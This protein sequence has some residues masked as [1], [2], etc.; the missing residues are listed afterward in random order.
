MRMPYWS[1]LLALLVFPAFA[2]TPDEEGGGLPG[3]DAGELV[4]D[5]ASSAPEGEAPNQAEAWPSGAALS[6]APVAAP[7]AAPM[8]GVTSPLAAALASLAQDPIFASATVSVQVVDVRTGEE[9]YQWGD[10]KALAPASVMKVV[11]TAAALKRLGPNYKFPTWVLHDAAEPPSTEGVLA[12]SLYVKGQGDP[13]MVVERLWRMVFD[14]RMRGIR[15]IKGDVVFDDAY[16]AGGPLV[17]G[18]TKAEDLANPPTYFASLGALSVNYNLHAVVV[19]PG[20]SVGAAAAADLEF[21]TPG[22]TLDNKLTTG[23]AGS[24]AWVKVE[25]AHDD[26][27]D[28]YT[29]TLTGNVPLEAKP[30]TI[31]R[32]VADPTAHY[33]AVFE[34]I[35]RQ[36]GIKVKGRYRRGATPTDAS[37][38]LRSD[39]EAL[40]E[41]VSTTS[42]QSNNLFA[43]QLLLAMGAE[44]YGLPGTTDSGVRVVSEYLASLGVPSDAFHL[45]NGSGLSR[46]ILVRPSAVDAVLV[47]MAR[48]PDRAP[49][50]LASLSVGGRDGTLWSRFRADGLEGRVRGKTGTLD[51]VHCLAG[52]V[53]A[54]D[55]ALYAFTFLVNDIDGSPARARKAHDQLVITLAGTTDNLADGGEPEL[56]GR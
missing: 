27:T 50:F 14:L 1:P 31:Y 20:A 49:E 39:S 48:D 41:I 23:K 7:V 35:A 8:A 46:E 34:T 24:K 2:Q 29:Y 9:V 10:D 32:P 19:R 44:V 40:S 56:P 37:V 16:F 28:V 54:A 13:T 12:G 55:D 51:G 36:Q 52:Y 42:K 15:E 22:V 21:P 3:V 25:R 5:G 11:T 6:A 43:E 38:V 4:A 17:P 47:D 53:R 30:D 26:A 33:M 18:W 45:V